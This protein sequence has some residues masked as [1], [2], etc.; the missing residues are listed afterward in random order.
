MGTH[1][2]EKLLVRYSDAVRVLALSAREVILQ[3]LPGAEETVDE[4]ARVIG[5]G[6]GPGYASLVCTLILS[7]E[8]VKLGLNRGAQ[9]PDPAGLLEGTGKVHRYIRLETIAD[10]RPAD[11]KRLLRSADAAR[12]KREQLAG[13]RTSSMKRMVAAPFAVLALTVACGGPSAPVAGSFSTRV[14]PD[15]VVFR[16][17]Y[18]EA[19][20]SIFASPPPRDPRFYSATMTL[21]ITAD[22]GVAGHLASVEAELVSSDGVPISAGTYDDSCDFSNDL[23]GG[24]DRMVP[25]NGRLEWCMG[26]VA[27]PDVTRS[28]T[29]RITPRIVDALGNV[30]AP[31]EN[32]RVVFRP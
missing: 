32:F 22:R 28:Y 2:I 9:L 3:A 15:P 16:Q 19:T 18:P 29:L 17:L 14:S 4:S 12:R 24:G 25:P 6:Y 5:Y 31:A 8:G 1:S 30:I 23:T 13:R 10:L 21:I 26:R 11:V 27:R 7:K 20:G